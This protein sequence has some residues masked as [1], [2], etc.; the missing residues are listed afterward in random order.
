MLNYVFHVLFIDYFV[1][2]TR[3]FYFL[4]FRAEFI[5]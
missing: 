4:R 1:S 3:V 5:G 2:L